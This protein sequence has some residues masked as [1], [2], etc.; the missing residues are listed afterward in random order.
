VDLVAKQQW[1]ADTEGAER[2]GLWWLPH[3]GLC[4]QEQRFL[5]CWF[6][7]CWLVILSTG[8]V[9]RQSRPRRP[10]RLMAHHNRVSGNQNTRLLEQTQLTVWDVLY[11]CTVDV[12]YTH[13]HTHTNKYTN[14]TCFIGRPFVHEERHWSLPQST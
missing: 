9:W 8:S 7:G 12:S 13:V 4:A 11:A 1:L 14:R 6:H 3:T 2:R 5:S 10:K